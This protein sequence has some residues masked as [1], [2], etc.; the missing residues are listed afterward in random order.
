MMSAE[1][2]RDE[3][4]AEIKAEIS[5]DYVR[6]GEARRD[7]VSRGQAR[8]DL[9]RAPP[10]SAEIAR[11][12]PRLSEIVRDRSRSTEVE[13]VGDRGEIQCLVVQRLEP[14]GCRGRPWCAEA[15]SYLGALHLAGLP[16]AGHAGTVGPVWARSYELAV[17][18]WA[19]AR[20]ISFIRASEVNLE[21]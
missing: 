10:S 5:G 11:D 8:S 3:E 21:E 19:W 4:D 6:F 7:E 13:V 2:S 18:A 15:R 12:C 20:H 1:V 9:R 16:A 14:D 17:W